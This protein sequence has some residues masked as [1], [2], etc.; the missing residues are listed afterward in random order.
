MVISTAALKALKRAYP[1]ARITVLASERNYE[2]LKHNPNVD[3]ILIYEGIPWFIREIRPRRY[4][5]VIDPFVTYEL[6]QALMTYLSRGKYRIGFEGQAG[7]S[8]LISE[9]P[10]FRRQSGWLSIC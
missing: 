9:V 2:V 8:S 5:L 4:D 3:E 7:R 6:K 1:Q 10:R